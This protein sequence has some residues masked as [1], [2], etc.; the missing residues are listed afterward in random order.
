MGAWE[1]GPVGPGPP[2]L[3]SW[4]ASQGL[5]GG[6]P[7]PNYKVQLRSI[8]TTSPCRPIEFASKFMSILMSVLGCFGVDLGSLLGVIFAPFGALV[9]LSWSQDRLRTVLSSKK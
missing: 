2:P 9:G 7:T 5:P 6:V 8:P 4:G 1:G 3:G